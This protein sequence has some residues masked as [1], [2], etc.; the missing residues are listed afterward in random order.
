MCAIVRCEW[1]R[2][3][4]NNTRWPLS[5]TSDECRSTLWAATSALQVEPLRRSAR[6]SLRDRRYRRKPMGLWARSRPP[7]PKRGYGVC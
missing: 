6:L 7:I 1:S 5:K 3:V 2:V 4:K